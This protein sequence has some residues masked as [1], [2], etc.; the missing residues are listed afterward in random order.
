MINNSLFYCPN[1]DNYPPFKNGFYLEEYFLNKIRNEEP[2]LKRKYIPALW[3]NFQIEYWFQSKKHDMQQS[4]NEWLQNNPSENGYFTIAQYDDGPLLQLPHNT[5]VYG[6]CSG[7][8]PIPLTYQDV[9]N[10]LES[11]PK[12]SFQDKSI[13]CS[14][15]GN[16]TSNHIQPNVREIMFDTFSNN[17]NF[18]MINSGGWTPSVNQDLQQIFVH[19]TIDSKFALAPRGYGRGSF[20]FFECFQLGTIPIYIWNDIELLPFKDVIDYNKLCISIH[21]SEINNLESMLQSVTE[22]DY[23]NKME[24]YHSIKYLFQLEG[25]SNQIIQENS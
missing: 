25:M 18:K 17:S 9:N 10:T 12:K 8:I 19:T 20:R 23:N 24:Y 14:F 7:D 5:I 21:I 11:F 15:I 16:I 3:T 1:K 22:E 13:L 4:L 6:A 2:T